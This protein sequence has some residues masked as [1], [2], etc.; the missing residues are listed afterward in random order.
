MFLQ[1]AMAG[2]CTYLPMP[3]PKINEGHAFVPM[4]LLM[5]I[6]KMNMQHNNLLY[7]LGQA[8]VRYGKGENQ[9]ATSGANG[10]PKVAGKGFASVVCAALRCYLH[11]NSMVDLHE[12]CDNRPGNEPVTF[13]AGPSVRLLN[14]ATFP[15]ATAS[16][17]SS[18]KPLK[19]A[20]QLFKDDPTLN[21]IMVNPTHPNNLEFVLARTAVGL[22][23][24]GIQCRE[25]TSNTEA[26]WSGW[27]NEV[28]HMK[29]LGVTPHALLFTIDPLAT[30]PPGVMTA[31]LTSM[32]R[33]MPTAA[34][35][36]KLASNLRKMFRLDEP[37]AV[38]SVVPSASMAYALDLQRVGK[39]G[40]LKK[41][42]LRSLS[43]EA[44]LAIPKHVLKP[45]LLA[46]LQQYLSQLNL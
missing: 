31:S 42:E 16:N 32:R 20:L 22:I 8:L 6:T 29:R 14:Y 12:L 34:I 7:H 35:N 37:V 18:F 39:L 11:Y 15:R 38:A 4:P 26:A 25:Y 46:A 2:S 44:G 5:G 24:L 21:V 23:F 36:A 45:E 9:T 1:A 19:E 33:W 27:R 41:D 3:S 10:T 17:R 43:N 30:P 40:L 28:A 13:R